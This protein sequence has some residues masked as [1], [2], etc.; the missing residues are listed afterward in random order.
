M[1]SDPVAAELDNP[2][3]AFF[4]ETVLPRRRPVI[5]RHAVDDWP[6]V[7]QWSVDYL[8]RRVGAR[9]IRV[10]HSPGGVYDSPNYVFMTVDAFLARLAASNDT[11]DQYYVTG[12]EIAD[13]LPELAP[14]VRVPGIV[15]E[16]RLDYRHLFIGRDSVTG[17]HF[18]P[19]HQNLLIQL[20]GRKQVVLFAPAD[21]RYLYPKALS[22]PF[23]NHSRVGDVRTYDPQQYPRLRDATPVEVTLE[24]GM[25]LH[26]PVHWWHA[27]YGAGFNISLALFW[28]A[29]IR[30]WSFPHPGFRSGIRAGVA[31]ARRVL[32]AS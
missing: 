20:V 9:Q 25:M 17:C 23:F 1:S 6:A 10:T 13:A 28:P 32:G 2:S 16:E 3:R 11:K 31:A 5:I 27:V 14:D 15:G 7:R 4:K 26:I 30:E 21:S 24:P 8:T 19:R 29:R 18:H 12:I 22:G